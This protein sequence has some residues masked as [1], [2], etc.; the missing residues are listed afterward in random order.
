MIIGAP[1]GFAIPGSIAQCIVNVIDH[2]MTMEEAI[3]APR[4]RCIGGLIELEGRIKADVAEELRR[5]GNPVRHWPDG[6]TSRVALV[7][8]IKIDPATGKWQT[9][10]DPRG[11]GGVAFSYA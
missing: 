9:G 7:H 10:A 2:G 4:L 5:M 3:S 1:G 8:G 6:Y 11:N